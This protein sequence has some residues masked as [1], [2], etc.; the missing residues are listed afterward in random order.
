[1]FFILVLIDLFVTLT[2]GHKKGMNLSYE[3]AEAA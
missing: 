3:F 2:N 1:M